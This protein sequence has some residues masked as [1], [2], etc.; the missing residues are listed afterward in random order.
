M[1]PFMEYIASLREQFLN[2]PPLRRA[3]LAVGFVLVVVLISQPQRWTNRPAET[4]L[5]SGRVFSPQ[6]LTNIEAAFAKAKLGQYGI[7]EGQVRVPSDQ[8]AAYIGAL[9]DANALPLQFDLDLKDALSK[10]SPFESVEQWRARVQL[11]KQRELAKVLCAMEAVEDASVQFDQERGVGLRAKELVTAMVVVKPAE[12]FHLDAAQIH[13]IRQLVAA[14]KASLQPQ[15]VTV[16]N[17]QTGISYSGQLDND[18][19]FA[20]ADAYALRKSTFERRWT[21]KVGSVLSFI[22]GV[23][24][25]TNVELID[26]PTSNNPSFLPGVV[27]VSVGI[28][29]SYYQHVEHARA[30]N[31]GNGTLHLAATQA[32]KQIEEETKQKVHDL[33]SGV[34]PASSECRSE[35]YVA[36]FTDLG[37]APTFAETAEPRMPWAQMNPVVGSCLVGIGIIGFIL[38]RGIWADVSH[39]RRMQ[40][41]ADAYRAREASDA[42][43]EPAVIKT[44]LPEVLSSEIS[45]A[46]LAASNDEAEWRV[47]PELTRLVR[48][49]P[50]AAAE[51][52][53]DWVRKAG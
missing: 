41:S 1:L 24:V 43:T 44:P 10:A 7:E 8:R 3:A 39:S 5:F 51:V 25:G 9:V 27:R 26:G 52:L 19:A 28:P 53:G 13:S 31:S 45:D 17:L 32:L 29:H 49:D 15:D 33:I 30:K 14:S 22:P 18:P 34:L 35:V 20:H 6:E 38:I 16:T 11:A 37:T 4:V 42:A 23:E 2:L 48:E 36:T 46:P 21:E 40:R 50:R 12:S 47:H